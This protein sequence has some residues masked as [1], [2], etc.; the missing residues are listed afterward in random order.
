MAC[1]QCLLV[2]PVDHRW[3]PA[4]DL[5]SNKGIDHSHEPYSPFREGEVYEG[6][7]IEVKEVKDVRDHPDLLAY[8]ID[9]VFSPEPPKNSLEWQRTIIPDGDNLSVKD[10]IMVGGLCQEFNDIRECIG[11]L[12]Q[13]PRIHPA[14][15]PRFM[16]LEP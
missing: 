2:H 10:H 8:L 1:G 6:L 4:H 3:I 16:K 7:A 9:P 14:G 5:G 15:G 12:L 13:F 11:H